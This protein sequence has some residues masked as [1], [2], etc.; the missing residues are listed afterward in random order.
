MPDLDKALAEINALRGQV[1]RATAFRGLGMA[2]VATTGGLAVAGAVTQALW[3]P[4]PTQRIAAWLLLWLGVATVS[5]ILVGV[6]M[7]TRTARVHS[8]LAQDMIIVAIEQF[9]P[10]AA[11][12]AL[13]TAIIWQS[14]EQALWM[15]PGLWQIFFSLGLFASRRSLPPAVV[16]PAL[17]Y[18]FTG[19]GCLAHGAS[20]PSFA[21]W[22]MGVPFGIGQGLIA[23]ILHHHESV[24]NAEIED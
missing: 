14:A 22:L 6:E 8:A 15:L 18:L 24:T 12:G 9:L 4:D 7:V 19:V 17:W 10:A 16:L 20:D 1:A 2:T 5:T 23:A 21:P 11:A 3:L 13:V